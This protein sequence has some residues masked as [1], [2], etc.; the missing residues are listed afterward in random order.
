M[1]GPQDIGGNHGFGPIRPEHDEPLF[2]AE[3]EARAMAM[4]IAAGATGHWT[5]DESRFARENRQP[6]EY[7]RL[8]Y[9]QIWIAGLQRLLLDKGL[10]TEAELASGQVSEQAVPPKRK[11]LPQDVSAVLSR[12]GP[13]DRDP[14]GHEPAY[15]VG[16]RVRTRNLQ[17]IGHTRLPAYARD[18]IG[19]IE[20]VQGYHIFA[21]TSAQGD[22]D[23]AEWLYTVVFDARELFGE[24]ANSRDEVTIDAWEPYL[25]AC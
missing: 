10:V 23:R 11:L 17:P 2:H 16:D 13:V 21:D 12:G 3:W 22:H 8:S 14:N 6:A 19:R 24:T 9:Y 25:D 5:I 20:L 7:Y 4:T 15:A 1:N 18:K